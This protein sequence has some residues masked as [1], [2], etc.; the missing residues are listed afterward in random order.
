MNSPINLNRAR[1][2]KHRAAK[3]KLA[4]ENARKHGRPKAERLL[5]AARSRRAAQMLDSHFLDE[6]E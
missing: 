3:K 1:K 2:L 6:P 4:D 5:E